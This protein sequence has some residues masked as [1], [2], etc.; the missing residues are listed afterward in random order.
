MLRVGFAALVL[1][2]TGLCAWLGSYNVWLA[3]LLPLACTALAA[4]VFWRLT[5]S[6]A[7]PSAEQHR[8]QLQEEKT[9]FESR[10]AESDARDSQYQVQIE[11]QNQGVESMMGAISDAAMGD[12]TKRVAVS[13]E[14]SLSS[15]AMSVNE[16]ISGLGRLVEQVR[17]ASR[18]VAKSAT[19]IQ[20]AA[21]QQAAGASEQ[22]A[23]ITQTTTTGEE[24]ATSAKQIAEHAEAVVEAAQRTHQS[25]RSAEDAIQNAM[26]GMEN[27]RES[28]ERI[29]ETIGSLNERSQKIGDIIGIIVDIADQ[30]K[31][32][33]LNA[34]IE[35][36][37]A[38]EAGKGFAVVATEIRS[39]ANNV[40][41]ST[42]EIQELL[43]EIQ[44]SASACV[45]ATEEGASRVDD[46]SAAVV[47]INGALSEIKGTID[48]TTQ[49][50]SQ[51]SLST[52]QQ[53]SASEQV[54]AAMREITQVAEQTA[55]A[56]QET[57]MATS[58]LLELANSLE[59]TVAS[60]KTSTQ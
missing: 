29:G 12:L 33:S 32:L 18:Q 26:Q 4:A 43:V 47:T 45:V 5:G 35:A 31:L 11:R 30:T 25:T 10:L 58:E 19:D 40:T 36:A 60:I 13:D 54:A 37:R 55:K 14:G 39:L 6:L 53:Q 59:M 34:A 9:S 52:R 38:G 49:V 2:T 27:I 1:A 17:Q 22:A 50:G 57:G 42:K 16:M 8:Q 7:E 23:S 46:G 3:S 28:S 20:T 56:S 44:K 48:H 24:L 51:I 41:E 15:L 21:A